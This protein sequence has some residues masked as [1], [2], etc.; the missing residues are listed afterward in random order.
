MENRGGERYT[1]FVGHTS[2]RVDIV[3]P[4]SIHLSRA[5]KARVPGRKCAARCSLPH[6]TVTLK[7]FVLEIGLCPLKPIYAETS[8]SLPVRALPAPPLSLRQTKAWCTPHQA[9]PPPGA[10]T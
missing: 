1:V 8:C 5:R 6:A 4:M 10:S 2:T 7:P 9:P 3:F